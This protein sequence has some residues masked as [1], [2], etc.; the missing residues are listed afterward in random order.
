MLVLLVGVAITGCWHKS[1]FGKDS[2]WCEVAA[3]RC[4]AIHLSNN[5][6]VKQ[7][8]WKMDQALTLQMKTMTRA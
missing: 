4:R 8:A 6:K 1:Q 7:G 2:G 5:L 3:A